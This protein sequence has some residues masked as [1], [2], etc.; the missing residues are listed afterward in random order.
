MDRRLVALVAVVLGLTLGVAGDTLFHGKAVGV[1]FPL[2]TA[3]ALAALFA[4]A[5]LAGSPSRPRNLW[6]LAP[7]CFFA[8]MVAVRADPLITALNVLAVMWL[9]A[10][11]LYYR[12]LADPLDDETLDEQ[13]QAIISTAVCVPLMPPAQLVA[14]AEWLRERRPFG[15][16]PLRAVGRGLL[17]ALPIVLVFGVLLGSADVIFAGYLAQAMDVFSLDGIQNAVGHAAVS[18]ALGWVC[19]GALAFGALRQLVP[20]IAPI[21]PAGIVADPAADALADD[22]GKAAAKPKRAPAQPLRLSMVETGIVF[23]AVNLMFGA[24]VLVQFTYFFAGQDII[25]TEAG[26]TYAQYARRGFFELVAV[27][28]ITLGLILWLDRVTPRA[29]A[30]Q[31][32]IFRVMAFGIVGLT[33][34]MLVSAS[35]RMTLYEEAYGFTH[36]RLYTHTFML[37]LGMLLA[38]VLVSLFIPRRRVFAFGTT[39][40]MIGFLATL[41]LMNVDATIARQNLARV[42]HGHELDV[43]YLN[44]LSV[45]AVPAMLSYYLSAELSDATDAAGWWL[46]RQQIWLAGQQADA[47]VFSAHLARDS[48]WQMLNASRES[49]PRF[50][51]PE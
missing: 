50:A 31:Q 7:L 29:T 22:F 10:L 48:A 42:A 23:G 34:V 44:T 36:L 38:V 21:Q 27:S 3:L 1:S 8:V 26:W 46:S 24:F 30:I 14:A 17:L 12:P 41:N 4:F 2:F 20:A 15:V 19:C 33:G 16:G 40:C 6:P 5:R 18:I 35:G 13:A 39:L 25:T 28:I 32:G 43:L 51:E 45:D 47:S 37:W 11:L 49:L 9:T